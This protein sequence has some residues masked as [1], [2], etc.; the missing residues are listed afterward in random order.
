MPDNPTL[1]VQVSW[2][3]DG[4]PHTRTKEITR[5][6]LHVLLRKLDLMSETPGLTWDPA[7]LHW[8]LALDGKE[9][10]RTPGFPA[11]GSSV[12]RQDAEAWAA[13]FVAGRHGG[14]HWDYLKTDI[15]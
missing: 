10:D 7:T 9:V 15:A 4:Q 3:V 11:G 8:V 12:T 1:A 6:H 13:R 2:T 14:E 5:S